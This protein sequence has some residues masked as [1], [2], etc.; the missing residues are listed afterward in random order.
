MRCRI[1]SE[2]LWGPG[3]ICPD[4][5]LELDGGRLVAAEV[6][7]TEAAVNALTP[8]VPLIDT[9][10][11]ASAPSR[12]LWGTTPQS[13]AI[14]IAAAC[15]V[16]VASAAAAYFEWRSI[17]FVAPPAAER[18]VSLAADATSH[19]LPSA[20]L[21]LSTMRAAEPDTPSRS[22]APTLALRKAVESAHLAVAKHVATEPNSIATAIGGRP[23]LA[24]ALASCKPE[25]AFARF[26]CEQLVRIR[27][28]NGKM[29]Q[30]PEC[31]Q[32]PI[33]ADRGS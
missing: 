10:R 16:A 33:F 26:V 4:C 1:C 5:K 19:E 30:V 27:Y 32:R 7:A 22:A 17:A 6:L 31:P 12:N 13:R 14:A 15:S 23:T 2:V 21:T 29:G 9:S 24:D 18:Y 11:D 28:C 20:E 8:L 25:F 3:R